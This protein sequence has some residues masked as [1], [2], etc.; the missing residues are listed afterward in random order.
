MSQS[1]SAVELAQR[2]AE[3]ASEWLDALDEPQRAMAS[4]AFDDVEQRT[5]WAYFPR[6]HAGLPLHDMDLQQQR[7][8]HRLISSGLSLHGYAKVAAIMALES[9]LNRLEGGRIQTVRDPGRYFVS[10]FGAPS[11]ARWGWR[12]EGHHVALNYTI[13]DGRLLSPTPLFL[14][15]NPAEVRHGAHPATRPCGEEEDIARELLASLDEEQ[16]AAA[17]LS[18]VAPPDFV[19]GNLPAVPNAVGPGEATPAGLRRMQQV[20]EAWDA[21]PAGSAAR[22]RFARGQ[23]RGLAGRAMTEPQRGIL[24]ALLDVYTSRLPDEQAAVRLEQEL[25]GIDGLHF[26]WAGSDRR[27]EGH[28]YRLQGRTVLIE[29]DNTQDGAN[30]VHSVW[31]DMYADFG[32]DVLRRHIGGRH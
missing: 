25:A 29:Y 23:P 1:T 13:V 10:I 5:D 26:A 30:H 9:V 11:D 15:A 19:L 6:D 3:E 2:M 18:P 32:M 21:L 27:G 16:R 17:T 28:Y 20:T 8:A 4:F 7:R 14:G 12:L 22:L 24:H 31:R